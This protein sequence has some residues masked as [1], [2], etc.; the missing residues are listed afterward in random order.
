MKIKTKININWC[1]H[2]P[3]KPASYG[4]LRQHS[5]PIFAALLISIAAVAAVMAA[6]SFTLSQSAATAPIVI[7]QTMRENT[8]L[9]PSPTPTET[10][11]STSTIKPSTA[12]TVES[13]SIA[14][15]PTSTPTPTLLSEAQVVE[16][17]MPY[18]EQYAA[19]NNRTVTTVAAKFSPTVKNNMLLSIP[20]STPQPV[21][22]F[23][24]WFVDAYFV[25]VSKDTGAQYWIFGYQ[26][27]LRADTAEIIT[28]YPAGWM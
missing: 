23:P 10:A 25:L 20:G 14:H 16:L 13:K 17:A 2:Q 11:L 3:P 27:L 26:V 5:K 9:N 8:I 18:I 1:P 12:P 24:G 22:S 15:F 19:E 4:I 7:D 28:A 6:Y 21:E